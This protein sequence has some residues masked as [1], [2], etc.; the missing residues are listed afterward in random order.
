[1][2]IAMNK[3]NVPLEEY[4]NI[5][6][7]ADGS[8]L[9]IEAK[10]FLHGGINELNELYAIALYRQLVLRNSWLSALLGEELDKW[11]QQK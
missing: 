1:M 7:S 9:H 2:A 4:K 8:E 10:G 3:P 11:K 6:A 5:I